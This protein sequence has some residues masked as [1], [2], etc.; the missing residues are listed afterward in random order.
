ML[1]TRAVDSWLCH[2]G[3]AGSDRRTLTA[4]PQK[5]QLLFIY[6]FY[7]CLIP[8]VGNTQIGF[9]LVKEKEKAAFSR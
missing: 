5:R 1:W 3:A 7:H 9:V 2:A 8:F 4:D 6:F